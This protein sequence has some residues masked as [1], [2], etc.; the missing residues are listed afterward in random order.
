MLACTERVPLSPYTAIGD[1]SRSLQKNNNTCPERL[2]PGD[3]ERSQV[4]AAYLS[5]FHSIVILTGEETR[6]A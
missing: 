2:G 1:T 5:N 4:A 6:E 3:P